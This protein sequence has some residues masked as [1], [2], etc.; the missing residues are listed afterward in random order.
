MRD[1]PLTEEV[2]RGVT[3][4]F[5]RFFFL[6][7]EESV[8]RALRTRVMPVVHKAY[9]D[10]RLIEEKFAYL[11]GQQLGKLFAEL[12][13]DIPPVYFHSSWPETSELLKTVVYQAV[14]QEDTPRNLLR[15]LQLESEEIV[16][17]YKRIETQLY[18]NE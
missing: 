13:D 1:Y 3:I 12:K 2:S 11:G 9:E 18:G 16:E 17:R 5:T 15:R 7:P 14:Q 8:S 6:S 4:Y 10:P